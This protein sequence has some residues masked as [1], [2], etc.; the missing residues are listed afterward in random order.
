MAQL[1]PF[2]GEFCG[3]VRKIYSV[4]SIKPE[5]E[6]SSMTTKKYCPH[7]GEGNIFRVYSPRREYETDYIV[8]EVYDCKCPNC[9]KDFDIVNEF[10]KDED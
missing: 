7:C 4:N 3:K 10:D 8:G 5:K 1:T 2:E 9:D 6:I